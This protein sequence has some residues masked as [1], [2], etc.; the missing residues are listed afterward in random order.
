MQ[1]SVGYILT[2]ACADHA[3]RRLHMTVAPS[4]SS[5]NSLSFS[6]VL[7]SVHSYWLLAQRTSAVA[8]CM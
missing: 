8:G 6:V 5:I 4:S 2:E 1:H 7:W 3:A